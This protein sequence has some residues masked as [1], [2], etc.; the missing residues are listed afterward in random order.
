ME[1]DPQGGQKLLAYVQGNPEDVD[2]ATRKYDEAFALVAAYVGDAEVPD[3]V[4]AEA[5]LEVGSK[6]MARQAAPNAR[7]QYGEPG[8]APLVA[9]RDPMVTVYPTLNRFVIG[10]LG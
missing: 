10:G 4:A 2:L 5:V 7:D 6:L 1:P 9:P 3:V 8:S